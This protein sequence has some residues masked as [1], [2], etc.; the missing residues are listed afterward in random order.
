MITVQYD[1]G[2]KKI[3]LN[4]SCIRRVCNIYENTKLFCFHTMRLNRCIII[5]TN[6]DSLTHNTRTVYH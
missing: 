5:E 2:Q 4:T 6:D 1:L 3:A